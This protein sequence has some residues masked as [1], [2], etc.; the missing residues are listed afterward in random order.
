MLFNINVLPDDCICCFFSFFSLTNGKDICLLEGE[1]KSW[2]ATGEKNLS[3]FDKT[4]V[5]ILTIFFLQSPPP[6]PINWVTVTYCFLPVSWFV[7]FFLASLL[8]A[9]GMFSLIINFLFMPF[10]FGSQFLGSPKFDS[11]LFRVLH[12]MKK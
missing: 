1:K 12:R 8:N 4:A 7:S 5:I 2:D 6:I 10:I 3:K 11:V 9:A